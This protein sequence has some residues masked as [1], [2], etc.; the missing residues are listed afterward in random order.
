MRHVH[1]S[2]LIIAPKAGKLSRV[3]LNLSFN[4]RQHNKSF[5]SYNDG[6]NTERAYVNHYPHDPLP[7]L[8]TI[9]TMMTRQRQ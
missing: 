2:P 8:V 3:C 4:S 5:P 7:T 9:H 1:V 6:V